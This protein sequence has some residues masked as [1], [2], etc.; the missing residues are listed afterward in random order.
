MKYGESSFVIA[1]L[2]FAVISGC[3]L[4]KKAKYHNEK[5]MGLSSLILGLETLFISFLEF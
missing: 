3:L 1:Y 4:I 5:L 2:M